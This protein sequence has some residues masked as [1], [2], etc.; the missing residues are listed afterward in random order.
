MDVIRGLASQDIPD[1]LSGVNDLHET[2]TYQ[3]LN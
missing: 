1:A 2:Y 3:S